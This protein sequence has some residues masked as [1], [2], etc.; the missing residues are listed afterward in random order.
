[1]IAGRSGLLTRFYLPVSG[2]GGAR[3]HDLTGGKD[4]PSLVLAVCVQC[5]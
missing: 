2:A 3:T 1:M 5:T 4:R